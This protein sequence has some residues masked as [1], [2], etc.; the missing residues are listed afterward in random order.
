MFLKSIIGHFISGVVEGKEAQL[1]IIWKWIHCV[2]I[3]PK[4]VKK[5]FEFLEQLTKSEAYD[6]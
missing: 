3:P 1:N 6:A 2:D 5:I 4:Y